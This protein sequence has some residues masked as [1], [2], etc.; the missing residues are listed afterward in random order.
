MELAGPGRAV[1]GLSGQRQPWLSIQG[2]G[3]WSQHLRTC[4]QSGGNALLL[5][6]AR[7][8]RRSW[9]QDL[10]APTTKV[11]PLTAAA[12]GGRAGRG[13]LGAPRGCRRGGLGYPQSRSPEFL[14][15]GGPEPVLCWRKAEDRSPCGRPPRPAGWPRALGAPLTSHPAPPA[16]VFTVGNGAGPGFALHGRWQRGTPARERRLSRQG[17]P[18]SGRLPSSPSV[19]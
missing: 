8:L 4:L 5:E 19:P 17:L 3:L 7:G 9:S 6:S 12:A 14:K 2:D 15:S 10:P 13:L 11:S 16:P 18:G 1:T